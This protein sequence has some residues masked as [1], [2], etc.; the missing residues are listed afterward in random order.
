MHY[1]PVPCCVR[2]WV[3]F[4][5][6]SQEDRV[7]VK[8]RVVAP[9]VLGPAPVRCACAGGVLLLVA[10]AAAATRGGRSSR[11]V[12]GGGPRHVPSRRR[13]GTT[14]KVAQARSASQEEL[15]VVGGRTRLGRRGRCAV[16]VIGVA[17]E[18]A[19]QL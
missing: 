9:H 6:V 14:H 5:F 16:V 15:V 12:G 4:F 3:F 18:E 2:R 8:V 10:V 11:R 13:T 17:P 7:G 19:V 1:H